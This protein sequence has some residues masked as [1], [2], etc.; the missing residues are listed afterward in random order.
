[1]HRTAEQVCVCVGGGRTSE[2]EIRLGM[3][4]VEWAPLPP[5]LHR[6]GQDG[7]RRRRRRRAAPQSRGGVETADRGCS[8]VES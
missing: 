4:A 2:G 3:G 8:E 7:V 5:S 1:M 6:S